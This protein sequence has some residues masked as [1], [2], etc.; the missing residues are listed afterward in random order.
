M[1]VCG[2]LFASWCHYCKDLQQPWLDTMAA[3][4]KQYEYMSKEVALGDVQDEKLHGPILQKL[5][6]K[7]GARQI[8]KVDGG[9]P[10]IFKV[11]TFGNVVYHKGARTTEALYQFFT[12]RPLRRHLRRN[13]VVQRRRTTR[14]WGGRTKR[15]R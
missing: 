4:G 6:Q 2:K 5:S 9:Y 14:R 15:R 12:G 13:T 8:I 1:I 10:T 3:I 11:D 7:M